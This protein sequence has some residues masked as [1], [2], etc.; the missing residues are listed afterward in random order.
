[1]RTYDNHFLTEEITPPFSDEW[2]AKRR[3]A[4]AIKQL[5]EVLVTSSPDID[6]MHS[7]AD[8][9]E[10]TAQQFSESPRIYGRPAWAQSKEHGNYGQIAH[11]LNPLSGWSNPIA[12]PVRRW[13]E[14]D[15]A[16]GS[17]H[18]GWAYEGPPDSVHGGIVAAIFDEFLGMAQLI[19]GQPGMTA[20]LNVKY[21]SPTPL[22]TDLKLEGWLEKT[23]GRKTFMHGELRAADTVTARCKALFVQPRIPMLAYTKR[24]GS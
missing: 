6:K 3:M 10:S 22:H 4:L 12:P 13:I 21:H 9:L 1:M 20:Y 14:D 19:G 16:Y 23:E 7:I 15:R 8:Q 17:C 11:E 18:C 24:D 2:E 5:T